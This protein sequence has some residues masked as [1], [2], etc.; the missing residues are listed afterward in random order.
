MNPIAADS[1]RLALLS[2]LLLWQTVLPSPAN[3][4]NQ[5][6]EFF[7]LPAG[8]TLHFDSDFKY[9]D[10][11]GKIVLKECEVEELFLQFVASKAPLVKLVAWRQG[12]AKRVDVITEIGKTFGGL[13]SFTILRLEQREVA[14]A[15]GRMHDASLL[16]I[17]EEETG[18]HIILIKGV[19]TSLPV[20]FAKIALPEQPETPVLRVKEGRS[21]PVSAGPGDTAQ[22]ISARGDRIRVRHGEKEFDLIKDAEG[23]ENLRVHG[24]FA[25]KE[26]SSIMDVGIYADVPKGL[27]LF[28]SGAQPPFPPGIPSNVSYSFSLR[29]LRRDFTLEKLKEIGVTAG[30][31]CVTE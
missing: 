20:F 21:F 26:A 7:F 29:G 27:P 31:K 12:D 6:F 17:R 22:L 2:L 4:Q 19:E 16:E 14:G 1:W 5:R 11:S 30:P 23:T 18:S 24:T 28:R 8:V 3:A 10:Y 9:P 13:R 15:D 25:G